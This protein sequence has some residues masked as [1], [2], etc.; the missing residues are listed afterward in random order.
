METTYE[1]IYNIRGMPASKREDIFRRMSS[2]SPSQARA[3]EAWVE[4]YLSDYDFCKDNKI[5]LTKPSAEQINLI[6]AYVFSNFFCD[7]GLNQENN[8]QAEKAACS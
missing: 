6:R 2:L 8:Q 1:T 5:N 3:L 7:L 4:D